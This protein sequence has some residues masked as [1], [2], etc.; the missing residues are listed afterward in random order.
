MKKSLVSPTAVLRL[1]AASCL[2]LALLFPSWAAVLQV[3]GGYYYGYPGGG[4]GMGGGGGSGGGSAG[5]GPG[6][7]IPEAAAIPTI[8]DWGLPILAVLLLAAVVLQRRKV[9]E[10]SSAGYGASGS[11]PRWR[12]FR[13]KWRDLRLCSMAK[14][15]SWTPRESRSFT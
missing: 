4:Y 9:K 13:I 2:T 11:I 3:V 5:G 8:S 7:G 6:S 10:R 14:S 15:P 12:L 1:I